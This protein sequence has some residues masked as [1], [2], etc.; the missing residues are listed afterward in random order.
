[1]WLPLVGRYEKIRLG[2]KRA[3]FVKEVAMQKRELA[4]VM[5]KVR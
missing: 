3:N 4:W 2:E 5:S 1:V